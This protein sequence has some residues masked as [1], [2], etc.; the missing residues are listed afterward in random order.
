MSMADTYDAV[1]VGGG[2]GGLTCGLYLVQAGLRVLL[3]E[4]RVVPG[5]YLSATDGEYGRLDVRLP[6][7]CSQ[8]VV[9]PVLEELG[10]DRRCLMMPAQW[11]IAAPGLHI[12][13]DGMDSVIGRL[14]EA[15]PHESIAI[16]RYGKILTEAIGWLK[17]SF[18]P[19]PILQPAGRQAALFARL[20]A[21]FGLSVKMARLLLMSTPDFLRRLFADP[22]LIRMLAS[23][24]YP[25][26]P[27]LFHAGMWYLFLE[28]YWMPHGGLHGFAE[29]FSERFREKG[30]TML[31]QTRVKKILVRD[32]R[33]Y[34]VE[35]AEDRR[36]A[37]R[38]VI[39]AM[40]YNTV[41]NTLLDQTAVSTAF[42]SR[43]AARLP[44]EPYITLCLAVK[45]EQL[46]ELG[47]THTFW[48]PAE[49]F[50]RGMIISIPEPAEADK[51]LRS[52]YISYQA[53]GKENPADLKDRLLREYA[54]IT[55]GI[56][57]SILRWE[58]WHPR[59]YAEEFGTFGGAS[60][61]WSLHPAHLLRN[62][63]P[64]WASPV[65]DLY[66]ACQWVYSPGGVPS[67]ML[68]A[69]QVSRAILKIN[70]AERQ[71]TKMQETNQHHC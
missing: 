37:A 44:S 21:S 35:V 12:P 13:I 51:T 49:N 7:L 33:A 28:D 8:G 59:R 45:R 48:F 3:C 26:M 58:L 32:G 27:A 40:D 43:L 64:G 66:H 31:L 53:G 67:A 41:Y 65:C 16:K 46:R 24:G 9:F 15:F 22:Q 69:R 29:Q 52:V 14:Q 54:R 19:H 25:Q 62:G 30:G 56:D 6:C 70:K 4:Q 63:F 71:Q 10:M 23:L 60:A 5:G 17:A 39:A 50:P 1:I 57:T 47:A 61:G 2:I 68:S 34:G 36:I 38:C 20:L 55:P 42:R 11:Q 18:L